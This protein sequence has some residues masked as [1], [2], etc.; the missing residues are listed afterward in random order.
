M[1]DHPTA[2]LIDTLRLARHLNSAASN[3]LGRL[4]AVHNLTARTD[5]LAVGSQQHRALWDTIA[6]T[7]LLG[8]LIEQAWPNPPTIHQLTDIAGIPLDRTPP[9]AACDQPGLFDM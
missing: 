9:A 3:G 2:G 8:T 6:A 4:V 5:A 7:I 1:A